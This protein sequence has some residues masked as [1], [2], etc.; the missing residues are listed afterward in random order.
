MSIHFVSLMCLC[1]FVIFQI[2]N[3]VI[4]DIYELMQETHSERDLEVAAQEEEQGRRI[5]KEWAWVAAVNVPPSRP[6]S[7]DDNG[8][9]SE[10][11]KT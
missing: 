7:R 5:D 9:T 6:A 10:S 3:C 4:L 8:T 11:D 2:I 1:I